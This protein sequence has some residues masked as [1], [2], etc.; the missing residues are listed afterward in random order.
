M[1][2]L[3]HQSIGY[4]KKSGEGEKNLCKEDINYIYNLKLKML[5]EKK[6]LGFQTKWKDVV[7]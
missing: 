4:E 3:T 6:Q 2:E 1:W 7:C 5:K